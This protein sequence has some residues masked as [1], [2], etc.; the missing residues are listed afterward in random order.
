MFPL[1]ITSP[2]TWNATLASLPLAH[3]LQTWE[4]GQFKSRHGW[5]PSYLMWNDDAG[6]ARAAALVLR[7]QLSRLPFCVMYVPKGP[8]MDYDDTLLVNQVLGDLAQLAHQSHAIF[9]K[10]DPDL[11]PHPLPFSLE[12]RREWIESAEQIQFRNTMEIDLRQSEDELL[13]AMHQKTRY[14]IRLAQKRGVTVRFGTLA[15]LEL[16]YAMYDETARRDRFIIRPLD[17]YR[18]AWGS[19]IEASLAQPLIAEFEGAPIAAL[20][21]F[22]FAG[23]AYYFYGMSRDAH[24]NLMAPHL[25]QWEAM[26]W[27]RA[28]GYTVY[29]MWGAPDKLDESDP[30][31]GVYRFKLGFGGHFVQHMGAWDYAASRPLYWLYTTAMPRVLALMRRQH[32][33]ARGKT[34]EA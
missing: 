22:H 18:D 29:D 16:L 31:W 7:R 17:Y 28:Q 10:I 25:L 27:V 23:R 1:S 19:F 24:R 12:G 14:N 30:M 6:Q 4:W 8:A 9:I 11:N 20:I 34:Q 5:S 15:N 13:A 33:Q 26:R 2:E 3:V 32:W 21:L